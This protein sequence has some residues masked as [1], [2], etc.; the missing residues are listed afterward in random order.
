[1]M[2][3]FKRFPVQIRFV[4]LS[5]FLFMIGWGLGTDTYFSIYVKKIIANPW[6]VT[7]IGAILAFAK[8]IFVVPV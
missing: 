3:L 4:S 7:L 1:M 6:G 8:L 5:L 2:R